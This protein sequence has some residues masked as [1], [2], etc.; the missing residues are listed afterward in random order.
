MKRVASVLLTVSMLLGLAACGQSQPSQESPS[1]TPETPAAETGAVENTA[2]VPEQSITIVVPYEAGGNT[3]IPMRLFAQYMNKYSD[4]EFTI[5]NIVGASGRTGALEVKDAEPDG[6]TLVL[7]SS[8]FIMQYGLGIAD[9]TYEDFAPI[10]YWL[11]STMA[12][13][14]NSDSPYETY[15]DLVEAAKANEGGLRMG[16]VTGTL[17][18]FGLTAIEEHEGITFNKVDLAGNAKAPEL[19]SGRIDGYID[20]FS[21]VKQYVDSGDF[22]CLAILSSTPQKGYED[23]PTL[24]DLGYEDIDYLKQDFGLWAPKG[25]PAEAIAYINGVIEQ[26][27]ADPE[28]IAELENLGYGTKYTPTEEYTQI[29]QELYAKFEEVAGSMVG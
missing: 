18:L 19:L 4:Q 8:G 12:L 22:R 16:S 3:D 9:F 6:Y 20:G 10:G 29:M 11:D 27:A 25:T 7:Q 2:W 1:G 14:V 21:S 13:V 17:P 28:C 15:E 24:A 5:T 26:A 23:I